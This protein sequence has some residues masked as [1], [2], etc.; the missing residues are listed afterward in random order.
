M[1]FSSNSFAQLT[2]YWNTLLLK[3]SAL[4]DFYSTNIFDTY[5]VAKHILKKNIDQRLK[6]G[7]H[8][9]VNELARVTIRGKQRN[10]Y[11]FASKYCS[12]HFPD[13]FPI[14]DSYVE[15]MLLYYARADYFASFHKNDLKSYGSFVEIIRNFQS[16]YGLGQFSL[17]RS[18]FFSGLLEK[19]VFQDSRTSN[20]EWWLASDS[21]SADSMK[22][23]R[24]DKSATAEMGSDMT[25]LAQRGE[26]QVLPGL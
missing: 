9:L 10:F 6:V 12:H 15:K 23:T 19:P 16:H 14:Y 13:W 8:S 18:I 5:S 1:T 22:K 11:S 4:N 21:A 24:T 26:G 25:P 20:R 7:D 17:G 2:R 3:V